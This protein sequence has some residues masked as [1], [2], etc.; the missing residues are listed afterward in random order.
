MV[1]E[2]AARF[3]CTTEKLS[4]HNTTHGA[5]CICV[6]TCILPVCYT[7]SADGSN[8]VRARFNDFRRPI[9]RTICAWYETDVIINVANLSLH[10]QKKQIDLFLETQAVCTTLNCECFLLNQ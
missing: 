6:C 2:T 9:K 1:N 10:M 8:V 7:A 3:T 4:F 5:C